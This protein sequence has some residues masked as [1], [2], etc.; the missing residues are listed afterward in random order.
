MTHV[1][2]I[3]ICSYEGPAQD[4]TLFNKAIEGGPSSVEFTGLISWLAERLHNLSGI[5][6]TV[7]TT[8]CKSLIYGNLDRDKEY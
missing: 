3:F 1:F 4:V 8:S 6:N 5:E 7:S 2:V